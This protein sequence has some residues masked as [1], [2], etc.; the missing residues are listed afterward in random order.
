MCLPFDI[1]VI[2]VGMCVIVIY[3]RRLGSN[4]IHSTLRSVFLTLFRTVHRAVQIFFFYNFLRSTS[5]KIVENV[6]IFEDYGDFKVFIC[7]KFQVLNDTK[8]KAFQSPIDR[9][10]KKNTYVSSWCMISPLHTLNLEDWVDQRLLPS[11]L[12]SQQYPGLYGKRY[13]W[14]N[15]QKKMLK[16]KITH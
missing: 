6:N 14:I 8:V 7:T 13:Y 5:V 12:T 16:S 3:G 11:T 10:Q 1:I 2:L 9:Q 15:E 4:P